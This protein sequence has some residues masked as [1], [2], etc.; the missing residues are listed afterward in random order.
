MLPLKKNI[1]ISSNDVSQLIQTHY[2]NLMQAFYELQSSFLSDIYK[3]YG[4]K[5]RFKLPI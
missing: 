1:S 5:E 2:S 4:S 3:R